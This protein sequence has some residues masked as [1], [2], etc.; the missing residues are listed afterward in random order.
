M[1]EANF[2]DNK[3]KFESLMSAFSGLG[4]LAY[5]FVCLSPVSQVTVVNTPGKCHPLSVNTALENI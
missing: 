3:R 1:L 5:A 2:H 4:I